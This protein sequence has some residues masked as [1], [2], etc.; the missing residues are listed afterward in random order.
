M[1]LNQ[2]FY[3]RELVYHG[4]F[5]RASQSLG[6]SQPALSARIKSLEAETELSLINRNV[7][8][9]QL[10]KDGEVFY[11]MASEILQRVDALMDLPVQ[12][13][14]EV[15]GELRLGMIPTVAPY[16][17][18]LF[19]DNLQ[20]EYPSLQL[21]IEELITEN[22]IRKIR[23]GHLDAGIISTPV[24]TKK[25]KIKP[26]FYERFFLYVSDKHPLYHKEEVSIQEIDLRD[27]WYL[28]EGNCFRN[29]VNAI[30]SLAGK[31][32]GGQKLVYYSNSIE[33][34]RRIVESKQGMTFIPELSTMLLPS[35]QEEM[36][37]P[38]S[39]T[40]PVR[41]ISLVYSP[42]SAKEHLLD[43]FTG[44]ALAQLPS[45]M[46]TKPPGWVVDTEVKL[47]VSD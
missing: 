1:N 33:S 12:L 40:D 14:K 43:A 31:R 38:I 30:C 23:S 6:I 32:T 21:I 9:V 13:S 46:K 4:S 16:F 19:I 7:K 37:K 11:E 18:S 3:L 15:A 39:G 28:E 45:R 24:E 27:I 42:Y 20:Q 36:I 44:V 5:T 26:L 8:P 17:V 10:T 47:D 25:F 41:E 34:L 35:E 2:L 29:Q 22:I